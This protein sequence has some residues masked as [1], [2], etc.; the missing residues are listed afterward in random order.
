ML[1]WVPLPVWNTTSGKWSISFSEI[2]FM[3]H[4]MQAKHEPPVHISHPIFA[5]QIEKAIRTSSAAWLIAFPILGSRPYVMFTCAADFFKTPK[6]FMSGGGRRSVGPPIS[7]F[8]SELLFRRPGVRHTSS[9]IGLGQRE[10]EGEDRG[11]GTH[12]CVCAP[13]YRPAGT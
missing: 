11:D 4:I 1:L 7:K 10:R 5:K 12:R 8:C 3:H 2:T 9:R 6:A 13:Q